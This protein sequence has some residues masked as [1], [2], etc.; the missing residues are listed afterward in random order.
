MERQEKIILTNMCMIY[1]AH[2]LMSFKMFRRVRSRRSSAALH[3]ASQQ[4][5]TA[6][7][8]TPVVVLIIESM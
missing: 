4:K 6:R 3:T 8:L 7:E 1:D 5:A 2:L